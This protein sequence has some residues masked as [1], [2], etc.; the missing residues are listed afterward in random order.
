VKAFIVTKF[1]NTYGLPDHI[2]LMVENNDI[3]VLARYGD[4]FKLYQLQADMANVT[5]MSAIN[6]DSIQMLFPS[7]YQKM[8]QNE[9]IALEAFCDRNHID[10]S[11]VHVENGT[12]L[13][14]LPFWHDGEFKTGIF[15]V[16]Q[17]DYEAPDSSI[18][19]I[20]ETL[21]ILYGTRD[22]YEIVE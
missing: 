10:K 13:M 9:Q 18:G 2:P 20:D 22:G 19:E 5:N 6:Y 3:V 11:M 17:I 1:R 14:E 15:P 7:I 8:I 4:S 12:I 21:E 16:Q